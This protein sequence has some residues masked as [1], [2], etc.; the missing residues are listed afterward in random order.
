MK[1]VFKELK[2]HE[3]GIWEAQVLALA[4]S[5]R[6]HMTWS[7]PVN[8]SGFFSEFT[9]WV[10]MATGHLECCFFDRDLEPVLRSLASRSC[11]YEGHGWF[12]SSCV[13]TKSYF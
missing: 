6:T 5:E 11:V 12:H 8:T 13:F 2:G 4:C 3:V 1:L 10:R 9:G 7:H